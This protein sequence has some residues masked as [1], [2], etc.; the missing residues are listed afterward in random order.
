[1]DK[2]E[3]LNKLLKQ[4]LTNLKKKCFPYK[5]IPFLLRDITIEP[6]DISESLQASGLYEKV[7]GKHEY[8]YTHKI[9]I[10]NDLI[11]KYL[12]FKPTYADRLFGFGKKYYK[13]KLSQVLAH[14]VIHAFVNEHYQDWSEIEGCN[15]DASPIFL[16]ILTWCGCHSNHN[17]LI[18][19]KKSDL[20]KKIKGFKT[21]K[22][23]DV[24]LTMLLIDYQKIERDLSKG[25]Q[26][27]KYF[28]LNSFEFDSRGSGMKKFF[29]MKKDFLSKTN[30]GFKGIETNKFYIGACIQPDQIVKLINKKR[31]S[32]FNIYEHSKVAIVKNNT[33]VR[34]LYK[35]VVG[36]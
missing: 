6:E 15:R 24:Y 9:T 36:F 29:Q 2:Q 20:Y 22:E 18:A 28:I 35:E 32:D 12:N 16:S 11:N 10:D 4:E 17:C 21:F 5:H 3:L 26:L 8:D 13:K 33:E 31:N 23:L 34:T 19:F 1:M 27:G 25:M 30:T 14:E 7:E